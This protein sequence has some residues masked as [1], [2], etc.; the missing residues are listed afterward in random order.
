MGGPPIRSEPTDT[1]VIHRDTQVAR[2]FSEVGWMQ[3]FHWLHG[4]NKDIALEF[5]KS[6]KLSTATVC[7]VTIQVTEENIARV[8]GLSTAG[9][10]W[11][12]R[13]NTSSVTLRQEFIVGDEETQGDKKG[14]LR[15]SLPAPW[16][17]V[18]LYIQ[19]YLT[20]KGRFKM[21]YG[22]HFKFLAHL[23]HQRYVSIPYFLMYSLELISLKTRQVKKPETSLTHH[24]L[25]KLLVEDALQTTQ[26]DWTSFLGQNPPSQDVE[27]ETQNC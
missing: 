17:K 6:L 21:L 16:P 7:R 14:T 24:G 25:I 22:Y 5:A 8:T 3:C 15:I 11:F 9:E 2:I 13:K 4:F 20:C 19:R 27:Q 1:S 18:S 26:W 10:K 12:E 23:R